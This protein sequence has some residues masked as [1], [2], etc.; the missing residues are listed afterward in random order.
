MGGLIVA[1]A[2]VISI[3]FQ[4]QAVLD[5]FYNDPVTHPAKD[6]IVNISEKEAE[7]AKPKGT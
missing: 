5:R 4:D 6:G 7:N 3:G 2:H 1:L